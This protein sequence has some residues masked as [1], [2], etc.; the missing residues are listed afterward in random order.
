MKKKTLLTTLVLSLLTFLTYI[1]VVAAVDF[2]ISGSGSYYI[3]DVVWEA[4]LNGTD[5]NGYFGYSVASG[6]VNGDGYVDMIVAAYA[7]NFTS[8]SSAEGQVYVFFGTAEGISDMDASNANI[9]LNG[10]TASDYFGWSVATGDVNNDSYADVIVGAYN[11]DPP[12]QTNAGQA[13]VFFGADYTSAVSYDALSSANITLNGT[14]ADDYF[15]W[16]VATGDVNNDTY[17]DVIVGAK[18]ATTVTTLEGQVFV[19]FGADYTS[20]VSYDALSSANITLNGTELA[21]F[22]GRSVATGD[23]NNDSYADV[24]VGA[25]LEEIS[26]PGQ[27]YVFFG[28]DY[29]SAVNEDASTYANLTFNGTKASDYFGYSVGSGDVNNDS[30]ADVIVGALKADPPGVSDAGQAYVFFGADYTSAVNQNASLYANITLNGTAGGDWFGR[31]VASGDVNNDR[32]ADVIIGAANEEDNTRTHHAYVFFGADYTSAVSYDALSSANITL[33]GT[34]SS[35]GVSEW[36][37]CSVGSGD[38]NNDSYADVIVGAYAA[39]PPGLRYGG[40][41][42]IYAYDDTN[43]VVVLDVPA[44][45]FNETGSGFVVFNYTATD[46]HLDVCELWGNWSG[47][48]HLNETFTGLTSG[49]T[50]GST[51]ISL[52]DGVYV[53]SVYC[54]DTANNYNTTVQNFTLTVNATTPVVVLDGP[55]DYYNE[56]GSG[57]VVFNYTAN[58]LNVDTCELWGNWSGWHL[59]ESFVSPPAY[60]TN[61]SSNISLGDGVYVWSVYCNDSFGNSNTTVE[62][63]TLTVDLTAPLVVLDAPVDYYNE[64]SSSFV[65]FNYTATD[66]H[67][68]VCELWGNW[69]GGWHLNETFTGL[70]SGE[71][72]GSSNVSLGDGVY[73]WSVYCNDTANNYNT[74]V[75]NFTLT[76]DLT[77]PVV[78]LQSP[79]DSSY[80]TDGL[81]IVFNFTAVDENPDR[82]TLYFSSNSSNWAANETISYSN[83]VQHNFSSLNLTD[84]VYTWNVECNST[85]NNPT[86]ASANRTLTVDALPPTLPT[87]TEPSDI[88]INPRDSITYTCESTDAT[89]GI[90]QWTWTLTRPDNT[91]IIRTGG[92]QGSDTITFSGDDDNA[93]GTYTV[94]CKVED[95]AGHTNT[96]TKTFT[97]YY[98]TTTGG[99]GGGGGSGRVSVTF[100]IDFSTS[101]EA[102]LN[103]PQGTIKTF[104]FDGS[105][106][107]SITFKEVTATSVT[108]E[109]SSTPITV[110]LVIGEAKNV[111][112]NADGVNDLAVKLNRI[113]SGKADVTITKV[114]EGADLVIE[115]E[116]TPPP[117]KETPTEETPPPETPEEETTPEAPSR[118]WLWILIIVILATAAT[119]YWYTQKKKQS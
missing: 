117:E 60:D 103:V 20:A 36:F 67:L 22:F 54:N 30:Y 21:G 92:S 9:T 74:T 101:D 37:G 4:T 95:Y 58:D 13:F 15:G 82:C 109:I 105:T 62:N 87:V 79:N 83:N 5:T 96:N 18:Q 68:D 46:T 34:L 93:A 50:N 56:T 71:T 26:E 108:L 113:T 3:D 64:T 49:E 119:G 8:A 35:L 45:F 110:T 63:F 85:F 17:A 88:S 61:G 89:S 57:F 12:G 86:F 7:A 69:S 6:D 14:A 10:T 80:D 42:Y 66:T 84:A 99:G 31:S 78:T 33:N 39:C 59:N 23:V 81:D 90:E 75:Q 91:A 115:Q 104:T 25:T 16:S 118:A 116:T 29:T 11:G 41:V 24:I 1:L 2:F 77:A 44:D 102:T 48:W 73:V 55:V 98:S 51:N 111:D 65:M 40:S 100:D 114:K 76:V 28:A 112:I 70:T 72:N 38:V 106:E 94:E 52:M 27:A 47:G 107:H 43:P 32:Y 53:W 97:T 19:F